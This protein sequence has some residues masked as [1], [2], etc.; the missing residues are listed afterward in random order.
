[1]PA[2][3]KRETSQKSSG[4]KTSGHSNRN[5]TAL[6]LVKYVKGEISVLVLLLTNFAFAMISLK[7]NPN[8]SD[9]DGWTAM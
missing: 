5:S 1:M 7:S 2:V 3:I 4:E 6:P 9:K 8:V